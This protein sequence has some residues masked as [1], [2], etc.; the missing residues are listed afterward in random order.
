MTKL[1]RVETGSFN[2]KDSYTISDLEKM[3]YEE[4]VDKLIPTD[5]LFLEAEKLTL[6]GFY[7]KLFK[8]GCEIYQ[9]KIKTSYPVSSFL[10]I[11]DEEGD[12]LA[13]AQVR[14]FEQG[15]AIKS[16]KFFKI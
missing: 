9:N 5:S 6:S 13:L 8:S 11:Y 1:E 7:L 4:R 10:R 14:E 12:F 3:S 16:I 2:V 15:T